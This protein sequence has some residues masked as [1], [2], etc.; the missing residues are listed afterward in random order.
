MQATRNREPAEAVLGIR[1][2]DTGFVSQV[3]AVGEE[4]ANFAQII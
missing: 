1:N 4:D 3:M 2:Y